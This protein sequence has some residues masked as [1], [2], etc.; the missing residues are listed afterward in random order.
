MA[1][2]NQPPV[3]YLLD[4]I[5]ASSTAILNKTGLAKAELCM[6]PR[7]K[8]SYAL[9][10]EVERTKELNGILGPFDEANFLILLKVIVIILLESMCNGFPF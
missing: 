10:W 5:C 8:K 2:I 4:G 1:T 3:Q 7:F 6:R 9:I